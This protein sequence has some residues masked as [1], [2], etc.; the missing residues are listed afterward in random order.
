M[1][2]Y[3]Y[4]VLVYYLRVTDVKYSIPRF[5]SVLLDGNNDKR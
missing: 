4:C 5:F 1:Q 2:A 3:T